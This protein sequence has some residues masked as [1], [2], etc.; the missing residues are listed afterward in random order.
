[1]DDPKTPQPDL[2]DK[3][4]ARQ[5]QLERGRNTEAEERDRVQ[6]EQKEEEARKERGED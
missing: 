1:M 5:E 3:D 4:K 2:P 6:G